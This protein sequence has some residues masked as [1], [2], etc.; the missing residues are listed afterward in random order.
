MIRI[1]STCLLSQGC[2]GC[3][4]S[5]THSKPKL[6]GTPMR[7]P[8][9]SFLSWVMWEQDIWPQRHAGGGLQGEAPGESLACRA[10][11]HPPPPPPEKVSVDLERVAGLLERIW[12]NLIS[13]HLRWASWR[14]PKQGSHF[15]VLRWERNGSPEVERPLGLL[16]L[17]YHHILRCSPNQTWAFPWKY[18][19]ASLAFW[20]HKIFR[21]RTYT[22][23]GGEDNRQQLDKNDRT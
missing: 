6:W 17:Q 15:L 12:S 11:G 23:A 18:I 3:W 2:W 4:D 21:I 8:G 22:V 16:S 13:L 5:W 19:E 14:R 1:L 9:T 7:K 20:E 10:L